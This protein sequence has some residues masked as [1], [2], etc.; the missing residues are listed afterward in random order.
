[1]NVADYRHLGIG[2]LVGQFR[3]FDFANDNGQIRFSD[4][5]T[6]FVICQLGHLEGSRR[7]IQLMLTPQPQIVKVNGIKPNLRVGMVLLS[8][9]TY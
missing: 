1:M 2:R 3:D 8:R 5:L 9:S 6:L 4:Y 7:L